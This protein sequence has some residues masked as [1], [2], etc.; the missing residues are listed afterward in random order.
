MPLDADEIRMQESRPR[1]RGREVAVAVP[2]DRRGQELLLV[3]WIP[4]AASQRVRVA[5]HAHTH[6]ML[7]MRSLSMRRYLLLAII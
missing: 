6:Q 4:A 3:A 7:S 1:A 5:L 2:V